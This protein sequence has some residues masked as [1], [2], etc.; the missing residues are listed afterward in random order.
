MSEGADLAMLYPQE[1]TSAVPDGTAIVKGAL[2]RENAQK[3]LDFTVSRDVQQLLAERFF[4]QSVRTDIQ[5][6]ELIQE[7]GPDLKIFDYDIVW[8]AKERDAIL[9]KWEELQKE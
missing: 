6:P 2:H 1:G 9:A 7:D 3:F 5:M 4:R 8:A